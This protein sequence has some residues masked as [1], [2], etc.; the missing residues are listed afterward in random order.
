MTLQA[1]GGIRDG[2]MMGH[3]GQFGRRLGRSDQIRF[4]PSKAACLKPIELQHPSKRKSD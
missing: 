1:S 3:A 2:A 4:N